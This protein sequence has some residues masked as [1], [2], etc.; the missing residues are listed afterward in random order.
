[1]TRS[2]TPTAAAVACCRSTALTHGSFARHV[3]SRTHGG[4]TTRIQGT[5]GFEKTGAYRARFLLQSVADLRQRLRARGSDL[6]VRVGRPEDVLPPLADKVNASRVFCHAEVNTDDV[7]VEHAV[8]TALQHQGCDLDT[9][10][11]C[12]LHHPEDLPFAVQQVP[13]SYGAFRDAMQGVRVRPAEDTPD[14]LLPWPAGELEPGSLPTMKELGVEASTTDVHAVS[15][16]L[17]GGAA[18]FMGCWC[19]LCCGVAR[20]TIIVRHQGRARRCDGL[21]RLCA[22]WRRPVARGFPVK[23]RR[24]CRAAASPHGAC[25]SSWQSS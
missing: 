21:G 11:G 14:G 1:M 12:T 20:V 8:Q 6:V 2:S 7:A 10:W 18:C 19:S 4:H 24:G 25:F 9:H 15:T 3:A 13:T 22:T 17:Q 16:G 5:A 23:S